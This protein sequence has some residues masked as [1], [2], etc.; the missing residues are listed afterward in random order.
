[1]REKLETKAGTDAESVGRSRESAEGDAKDPTVD[2]VIEVKWLSDR[3]FER[4]IGPTGK[5]SICERFRTSRGFRVRLSA[6]AIGLSLSVLGLIGKVVLLVV[7]WIR[8]G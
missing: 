8:A 4:Q 2:D 1:M 5:G 3:W 6:R 7:G